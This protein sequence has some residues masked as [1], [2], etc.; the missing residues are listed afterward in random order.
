MSRMKSSATLIKPVQPLLVNHKACGA[1]LLHEFLRTP[2]MQ[3]H[4]GARERQIARV[5]LTL[6]EIRFR[7]RLRKASHR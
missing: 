7:L 4:P 6:D 2:R 1:A 5:E 3:Q